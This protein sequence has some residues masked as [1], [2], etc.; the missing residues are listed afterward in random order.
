MLGLD[1]A[2]RKGISVR[3][4]DLQLTCEP[5]DVERDMLLG[6]LKS[7]LKDFNGYGEE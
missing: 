4:A 6:S 5:G 1:D 7:H 3:G 2:M